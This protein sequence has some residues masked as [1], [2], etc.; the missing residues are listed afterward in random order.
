MHTRG[1][2]IGLFIAKTLVQRS[3]GDIWVESEEGIYTEFIFTLP[4]APKTAVQRTTAKQPKVTK[5]N[6]SGKK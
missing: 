4:A 1:A 2:G 5:T 6:K 3:G